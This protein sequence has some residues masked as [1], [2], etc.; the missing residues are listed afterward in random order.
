MNKA[1]V[2]EE[3]S[4]FWFWVYGQGRALEGSIQAKNEQQAKQRAIAFV[5]GLNRF[6]LEASERTLEPRPSPSI[7][8]KAFLQALT[9]EPRLRLW[10]FDEKGS[11]CVVERWEEPK[12]RAKAKGKKR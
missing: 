7:L 5:R 12:K 10:P 4:T 9:G 2:K 6:L 3:S 11:V 8:G 1:T